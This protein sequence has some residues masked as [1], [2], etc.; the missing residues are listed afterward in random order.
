MV[1]GEMLYNF[2]SVG[3]TTPRAN[4]I[5]KENIM[6]AKRKLSA[7]TFLERSLPWFMRSSS[8]VFGWYVISQPQNQRRQKDRPF[9]GGMWRIGMDSEGDRGYS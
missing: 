6:A 3:A 2:I 8:N 7:M 5:M 1:P 9:A 4:R